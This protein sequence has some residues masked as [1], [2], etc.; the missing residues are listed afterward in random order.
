MAKKKPAGSACSTDMTEK[1][2]TA[3]PGSVR[4]VK[5][6]TYRGRLVKA[7]ATVHGRRQIFIKVVFLDGWGKETDKQELLLLDN[8]E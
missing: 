1:T 2:K 3:P 4:R 6:G 5:T 8:L 7:L